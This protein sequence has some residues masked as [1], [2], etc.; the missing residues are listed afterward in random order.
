M[1]KA[2]LNLNRALKIYESILKLDDG[3][4]SED[5]TSELRSIHIFT[6]FYLAQVEGQLGNATASSNH[7]RKTLILQRQSE[8]YDPFEWAINCAQ[9]HTFYYNQ[10][11]LREAENCL[12]CAQEIANNELPEPKLKPMTNACEY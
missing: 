6:L 12:L 8:A 10:N 2:K 9:L 5:D 7:V 11:H 1:Y 4:S 3:S